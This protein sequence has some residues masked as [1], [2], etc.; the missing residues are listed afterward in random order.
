MTTYRIAAPDGKTYR[1]EGPEGATQ[2]QIQAEVIRQNPHLS[3]G[4]PKPTEPNAAAEAPTKSA[5]DVRSAWD[6][7]SK[8]DI[9]AGLPATRMIAGAVSP[10]VGA[11]QVGVNTGDWLSEKLGNSS[12]LGPWLAKQIG[13]YE[14]AKKRGMAALGDTPTDIAGIVGS[15]ATGAAALKGIMPATT[16]LGKIAQGAGIGAAAGATT[17]SAMPG[18]AETGKQA[19]AGAA[20]GGGIPAVA[21]AVIG[22]GKAGYHMLVEPLTE[23]GRTAIKGRAY[24]EA[25]G[26]KAPEILAALRAP[27]NGPN[28]PGVLVPGSM[29]TAGQA[30]V[31]AGSAEWS[32][33]Q[34]SASEL[35][36]TD[37]LARAD[38]QKAAQIN[39]L[40]TVGQ[41]PAALASAEGTRS[42]NALNNYGAAMTEG[43][44]QD[45]AKAMAPQ[46]ENL[47][48]RP[49]MQDARADAVRWAKDN[50]KG[51]VDFGSL[52]GLDIL[53]KSLDRQIA[54]VSKQGDAMGKSDL[55]SL[56]QTKED[57]LATI[58]ELSPK[59]D[60]ARAGFAKDS[61]PINQMRVGQ[62]LEN[63]LVPAIGDDAKLRAASFAGAVRDAP[64]TLRRSL[65]SAPRFQ[66][67]SQVLNPQQVS[68]VNSVVDDLARNARFEGMAKLGTKAGQD[69]GGIASA[70]IMQ[71]G[72]GGK[73]PNP[74]SRTVTIANAIISR[75]EGKMDKKLALELAQE[76]LSPSTTANAL[77]N[78]LAKQKAGAALSS[79]V[80]KLRP[81][82]TGTGAQLLNSNN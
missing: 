24:A 34:K 63:K 47:M 77:S 58:K 3:A 75:V 44:D 45:M 10:V 70:S 16:Y 7:A 53:K 29:P 76:M 40:R 37:Y 36:P 17:P 56:L 28:P 60:A 27:T 59:Y 9:V 41:T 21:P 30:A 55:R 49:A 23:A 15:M 50:S 65:D 2:E 64:S 14:A 8:G 43:L 32:A 72:A 13:D 35:A 81:I 73:I 6:K 67:L 25:A 78:A 82:L 69:A 11:L 20:L 51:A 19:A 57:L 68:A 71:A 74:L 33:L 12:A 80:N 62:Y 39:Q 4:S 26:S 1:I 31:P 79:N 18:L 46:I 42:A 5:P 54:A 52:E 38:A 48:A 22:M 66:E 61:A